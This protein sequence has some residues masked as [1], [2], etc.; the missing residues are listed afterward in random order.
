MNRKEVIKGLELCEIG[1]DD[2]CYETECPY[3]G[4]GCT[5]DLK[6]DILELLKEQ[7]AME[8]I[9]EFRK[10]A[11]CHVYHCKRC[12]NIVG[13]TWGG[14]PPIAKLAIEHFCD[15]CGQAVKWE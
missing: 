12:G 3:Y 9:E 10:G 8:P 5:E 1:S 7:E 4:Q 11:N 13:T 14:K 15:V 6:N 2:R